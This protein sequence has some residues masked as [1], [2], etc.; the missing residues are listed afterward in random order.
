MFIL[1]YIWRLNV[2]FI[3]YSVQNTKIAYLYDKSRC[4]KYSLHIIIKVW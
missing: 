1:F 4:M 3:I 2:S